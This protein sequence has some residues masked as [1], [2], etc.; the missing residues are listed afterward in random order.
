[1]STTS[2]QLL[3]MEIVHLQNIINQLSIKINE[4]TNS[5]KKKLLRIN[6]DSCSN[7]LNLKFSEQKEF[8]KGIP[9][10]SIKN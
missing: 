2:L 8:I 5:E 6:I 4:E 1:M 10:F 3:K 9:F 7:Y